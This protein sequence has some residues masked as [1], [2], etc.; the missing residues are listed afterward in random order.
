MTE[1]AFCFTLHSPHFRGADRSSCGPGRATAGQN[2]SAETVPGKWPPPA[3]QSC[4][5]NS[6]DPGGSSLPH[7]RW[8]GPWSNAPAGVHARSCRTGTPDSRGNARW[9]GSPRHKSCT[10]VLPGGEDAADPPENGGS[11][12]NLQPNLPDG[13][14]HSCSGRAPLRSPPHPEGCWRGSWRRGESPPPPQRWTPSGH[15]WGNAA[16]AGPRGCAGPP[17]TACRRRAGRVG[18]GASCWS[19]WR[20]MR[21]VKMMRRSKSW[22][23]WEQRSRRAPCKVGRFADLSLETKPSAALGKLGLLQHEQ[24]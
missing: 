16:L 9:P 4:R 20:P 15:R 1:E 8:N 6:A 7:T 2:C 17:G 21:Y 14:G 5:W 11:W 22:R 19:D 23:K 13:G 18:R 24:R 12:R 10:E 3:G